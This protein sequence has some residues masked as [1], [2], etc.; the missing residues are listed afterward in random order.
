MELYEKQMVR[1]DLVYSKI[2]CQV[3]LLEKKSPAY[4]GM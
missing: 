4:L 3:R 2:A 1:Y